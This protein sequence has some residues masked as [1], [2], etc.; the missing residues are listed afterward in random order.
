MRHPAQSLP[1]LLFSLIL[2][3]PGCAP[4]ESQEKAPQAQSTQQGSPQKAETPYE[5]RFRELDRDGN[6]SVSLA[7]WPLEAESFKLVDRNQDGQLSRRELL[8][9]NTLRH[10]PF[11]ERFEAMDA[12]RDGR[13]S[14]TET[15]R[16]RGVLDRWDRNKD[17]YIDRPEYGSFVRNAENT[18]SPLSTGRDRRLFRDLDRNM[19]QRVSLLEW[20]GS[21]INFNH[22]D[23][24]RDGVLSP[25]E[26]Q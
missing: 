7:E 14:R 1:I 2:F 21:N 19:D 18:W 13:L 22:L 9:P 12:N 5:K 23:R 15:Q 4:A 24:N 20:R 10:D 25:N 8:T 11:E 16:D 3:A 26:W 6:G 17:G